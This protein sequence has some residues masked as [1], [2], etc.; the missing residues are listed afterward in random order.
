MNANAGAGGWY[1]VLG[2]VGERLLRSLLHCSSG[3]A[4]LQK[5]GV[6]IHL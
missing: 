4:K 1:G 5:S 2:G 6:G 3:D